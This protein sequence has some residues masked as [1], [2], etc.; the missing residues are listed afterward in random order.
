MSPFRCRR[1]RPAGSQASVVADFAGAREPC[2]IAPPIGSSSRGCR[3][4]ANTG[5]RAE[6][7]DHHPSVVTDRT[8]AVVT[9]D[10]GAW[11]I[12]AKLSRMRDHAHDRMG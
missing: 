12:S 11:L 1:C 5:P 2:S 6:S 10:V 3:L 7:E 8:G 4:Q 9:H